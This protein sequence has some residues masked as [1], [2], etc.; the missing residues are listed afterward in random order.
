MKT[1]FAALVILG[2]TVHLHAGLVTNGNFES[3]CTGNDAPGWTAANVD[4]AGGCRTTGGN[5]N[6]SFILNSNGLTTDPTISQTLAGLVFGQ[7]Y[8]ITIDYKTEFATNGPFTNAA[9]VEI[10]G[11]LFQFNLFEDQNWRKFSTTF[12][13]GGSSTVLMLTGERNGSDIAPRV[14]NVDVNAVTGDVPEPGTFALIGL[15]A[16]GIGVLRRLH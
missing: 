3:G 2:V 16:F 1:L 8:I 13:Y 5:P 10:D 7:T 12:V 14:D 4:S 9:G 6:G 11:H 15:G